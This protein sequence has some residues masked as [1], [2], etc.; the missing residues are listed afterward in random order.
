[1]NLKFVQYNELYLEKSFEWLHDEEIKSLVDADDFTKED[2]KKWFDSLKN[3]KDYLIWGIEA[4]DEPVGVVGL[5]NISY[6]Q[7]EA[8][9]FGYIGE[10]NFWGKGIGSKMLVYI[11]E[12]ARKL[13]LKKIVLYVLPENTRAICL[14][15]KFGFESYGGAEYQG[16]IKYFYYCG[17]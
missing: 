2:Q 5:K 1:M 14:Y 12:E 15:K 3:R 8:E 10:K 13:E 4:D 6:K 16:T 17:G 11:R 9:F 7:K